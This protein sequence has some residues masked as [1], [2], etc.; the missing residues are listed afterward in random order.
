MVNKEM[1]AVVGVVCGILGFVCCDMLKRKSQ[2]KEIEEN[3]KKMHL[4]YNIFNDWL[5][6]KQNDIS[7]AKLL[8]SLGY[9]KIAIYGM[10]ELGQRLYIEL[11]GTEVEVVCMIDKNANSILGEYDIL[12]LEDEIPEVDV[13]IVTACYYFQ[14]IKK[15]IQKKISCPIVSLD[16]IVYNAFK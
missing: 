5:C 8:Y 13:I 10:K 9:K 11:K 16:T 12:D 1:M 3:F 14:D 6:L 2:C 4:Y 15:S 7:I